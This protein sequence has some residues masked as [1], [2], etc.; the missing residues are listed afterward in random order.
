MG[1]AVCTEALASA[2]SFFSFSS[3][4]CGFIDWEEHFDSSG[5]TE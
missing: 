4:L 1:F 5:I 3:I 2:P